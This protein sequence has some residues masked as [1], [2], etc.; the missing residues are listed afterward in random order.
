MGELKG[1]APSAKRIPSPPSAR[2]VAEL[3]T[4]PSTGAVVPIKLRIA[5]RRTSGRR[6]AGTPRATPTTSMRAATATDTV[7]TATVADVDMA[8][9]VAVDTTDVGYKR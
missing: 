8:A 7:A 5:V 9:T 3:T 1:A 2:S 6:S 4:T